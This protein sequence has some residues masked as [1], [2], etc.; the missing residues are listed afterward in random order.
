MKYNYPYLKDK[1]FLKQ[2]DLMKMKMQSVKVTVLNWNEE[3][4][5]SIE[6]IASS[7]SINIDGNSSVRRTANLTLVADGVINNLSN[8]D[9]LISLNKKV[10]IEIGLKNFVDNSKYNE[11]KT[12]WFPQ[13]IFIICGVSITHDSNSGVSISLQLKD[14][15]CLLNGDVSGTIPAAVTLNE[16]DVSSGYSALDQ[17][18][19]NLIGTIEDMEKLLITMPENLLY[20]K[21]EQKYALI[22]DGKSSDAAKDTIVQPTIYQIIQEIVNHFG[23]EQIGKIIISDVPNR[24][25]QSMKWVGNTPLYLCKI[26]ENFTTSISFTTDFNNVSELVEK[27]KDDPNNSFEYK[28]ITAGGNVGYVYTD[29]TYPGELIANAGDTVCSI[30]DKIKDTLGNF[31]YFYDLNGNFVFQEIKNYLNTTQSKVVS[32]NIGTDDYIVNMGEGKSVYNFEDNMI[33]TSISSSPQYNMI[34][35][36]FLVWGTRKNANGN[37]VPIRYHVAIDSKPEIGNQ[38]LCVKYKDNDDGLT[39]YAIPLIYE[40]NLDLPIEGLTGVFYHCNYFKQTPESEPTPISDKLFF[41]YD[42]EIKGYKQVFLESETIVTKDWRSELYLQ[43]Q[44]AVPLATDSNYYFSELLNEW[45]KQYDLDGSVRSDGKPGFLEEIESDPTLLDFYLDLIDDGSA[46]SNFSVENIGR[47]QKVITDTSVN[48]I[49]EPHIEDVVLIETAKTSTKTK[50]QECKDNQQNYVL[51]PSNIFNALA[52]G[53]N[54]YSAYDAVRD[55]LYQYTNYNETVSLQVIPILYLEPNSRITIRDTESD[56]Y[57]D[58]MV[59]SISVPLDANGTMSL[60]CT[61]ALSKI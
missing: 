5:E 38:Y 25:K 42:E 49:F 36:D 26:T 21:G 52:I 8:V 58:Y 19:Y 20:Y 47:R 53:G 39:K 55:L 41:I 11:Y 44:Q 29:F 13:G 16:I 48:C 46:I 37:E 2:V 50:I 61:K 30:L 7:G 59:N 32:D 4:V 9:N 12:L 54:F 31:E 34:K 23:G 27:Y 14:K 18:A 15:M 60:S 6:G 17:D 43:G 24:I 35:N 51:V 45:P 10:F 1:N 40:T 28:K 33:I 22:V 56:I 57:G 3:P